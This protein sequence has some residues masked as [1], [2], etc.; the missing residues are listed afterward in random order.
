MKSFNTTQSL[1]AVAILAVTNAS[2]A[3]VI[4]VDIQGSGSGGATFVANYTG[5]SANGPITSGTTWNHFTVGPNPPNGDFLLDLVDHN[6]APTTVDVTFGT[7]WLGSFANGSPNNLQG[8][9][10]F[11]ATGVTGDITIGGLT[12]GGTYN[13]ALI[14]GVNAAGV[15]SSD[16]T[17]GA[18]TKTA[19]DTV[20][21]GAN[22]NGPLTFTEGGTH[23]LF[24]NIS[25]D[26]SGN[27]TIAMTNTAGAANGV[28]AG[29]QI[30]EAGADVTPPNITTL[31]PA[32]DA[33]VGVAVGT[34]LVASFNE[35]VQAGTS[36]T[37]TLWK[38]LDPGPDELVE[39]FDV[40]SSLLLTFGGNSVTI[41]PTADLVGGVEYYVL[42]DADAIVDT[43]SNSFAGI[44]GSGTWSFTTAEI[45][46]F[47]DFSS[48][49]NISTEWTSY[50]YWNSPPGGVATWNS[51]DQDLDLVKLTSGAGGWAVGVFRTG[52]TR[53]ATDPVTMTV[54]DFSSSGGGSW[55]FLGLMISAVA[56]PGYITT[57][58][59]TYTLGLAALGGTSVRYEVRR[60]Y[61]DGTSNFILYQGSSFDLATSAPVTLDIVRNG[62]HYEFL[63]NDVLLYTTASPAAGDTYDTAAKDSLVNYQ[64]VMAGDR[65][66]N[67]TV[68]D[69]G[70]G[71]ATNPYDIWAAQI[72]DT[73]QRDRG[74]DPDGD[75]F[76]N[77][78][79]FLFGSSPVAGNGSLVTTTSSGG[80][81]VLR[82]LQR[83]SGATY[84]LQQSATL[85]ALSWTTA[86][87]SPALDG[88]QTG[89]P[90]DYATTP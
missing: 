80:N 34:N 51:T 14:T 44:S 38:N 37:I 46:L 33:T 11:T 76:N 71:G 19:V 62:D 83:E 47:D 18:T 21:A 66:L 70:V 29:L 12:P 56:N 74:D 57:G 72:A 48:D 7:G 22:A 78:E 9:R 77:G 6:G 40:T 79:E 88:D 30:E 68:D 5:A 61:L 82:W 36:G 1:A 52:S 89:A 25:A 20:G 35:E 28:L 16:F 23:V 8:D 27:I 53:S 39:T 84:T 17:I 69:F 2:F 24:S 13:I 45:V 4:N 15:F 64:I 26:G 65:A 87:Q 42:I 31:A 55:G 85:E 63:A 60:T 73:N 58:D 54:K 81:L 75:G 67:A 41:D 50:G 86:A 3:K 32:D 49:P 59:D 10:V 90:T 43:A